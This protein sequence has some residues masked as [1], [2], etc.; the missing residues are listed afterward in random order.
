MN[1]R[2][3]RVIW[4]VLCVVFAATALAQEGHPLKGTWVGE[5]G[6]TSAQRH[7]VVL[8]MDWDGKQV[9]G[10]LNPGVDSISIKMLRLDITPGN[11]N[12]EAAGRNSQPKPGPETVPTF[13]VHIEAEGKDAMGNPV[14]IVADG[15]LEDIGI[16]SRWIAG[17]W[18]QTSAGKTE[19]GDFK[20]RRQ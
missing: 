4:P 17:T 10:A 3:I 11:P 7:R 18:S 19:K 5:W 15:P 1:A 20:I 9:T 2:L 14:T 16:P 8:V 12:R 13:K 6:P